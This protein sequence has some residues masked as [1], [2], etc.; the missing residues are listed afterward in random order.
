MPQSLLKHLQEDFP[1]LARSLQPKLDDDNAIELVLRDPLTCSLHE[2]SHCLERLGESQVSPLTSVFL[3]KDFLSRFSEIEQVQFYETLGQTLGSQLE[4]LSLSFIKLPVASLACLLQK[5]P[6]LQKVYLGRVSLLQKQQAPQLYAVLPKLQHLNDLHCSLAPALPALDAMFQSDTDTLDDLLHSVA[7]MPS[8]HA[9][10]LAAP[11]GRGRIQT[12]I[13]LRALSHSSI[14]DLT[15]LNCPLSTTQHVQALLHR[16]CFTSLS[17]INTQMGD[18]GA[19]VLVQKC[20][21]SQKTSFLEKLYL[22]GNNLTDRTGCAIAKALR[23]SHS[24][25]AVLDLH[26]NRLTAKFGVSMGKTLQLP[27]TLLQYLDVSYN[28]LLDAGGI[29]LAS[30]LT[31]NTNL[32]QLNLFQNQIS[33]PTCVALATALQFN[34]SLKQLNLYHNPQIKS[35]DSLLHHLEHNNYVL[36]RLQ[37]QHDKQKEFDFWLT[38]NR[39][40]GRKELL[41]SSATERQYLDQGVG[42]ASQGNDL[43]SLFY[44]LKAKPSLCCGATA[45][46]GGPSPNRPCRK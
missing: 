10:Y 44:F 15:L 3:Y 2:I 26:D 35:V 41:L 20:F 39:K 1:L 12:P 19:A 21:L 40:F 46:K 13:C 25:L 14:Q 31:H 8:L 24:V 9:F 16:A 32:Q 36:E 28:P 5:M 34:R 30:A 7:Q 6:R 18:L 38:L 23:S 27:S 37:V 42:Q 17:L 11:T 45:A 43:N 33:D 29:A 22:P 4:E